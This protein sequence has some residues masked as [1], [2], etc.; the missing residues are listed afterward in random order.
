MHYLTCIF[1]FCYCSHCKGNGKR[2]INTTYLCCRLISVLPLASYCSI[3]LPSLSP[4]S[5]F[6]LFS[7]CT[8]HNIHC[9]VERDYAS[10]RD[11]KGWPSEKTANLNMHYLFELI[12]SFKYAWSGGY[13]FQLLSRRVDLAPRRP[14]KAIRKLATGWCCQLAEFSAGN[15]NKN[16]ITNQVFSFCYFLKSKQQILGWW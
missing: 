7:R 10:C 4:Q 2:P 3:I 11:R 12:N 1:Y 8:V 16:K 15:I 9:T 6:S 5:F 14:D 13:K